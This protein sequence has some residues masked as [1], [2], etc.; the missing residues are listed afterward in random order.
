MV[1]LSWRKRWV[2]LLCAISA[3]IGWS[4]LGSKYA[5]EAANYVVT[6]PKLTESIRIVQL[7]DLHNSEF[8]K[9]NTRLIHIVKKQRP[10]IILLTGDMLN[11]IEPETEVLVRLIEKLAEIAPVY[12]SYGNHEIAHE[13]AYGTDMKDLY[14]QAG[15]HMLERTYID[16]QIKGQQVRIG[17]IYGYCFPGKYA[18]KYPA[19]KRE[20]DYLTEFQDTDRLS[21]LL[22]HLPTNWIRR[23]SLDAWAVDYVFSGHAHGGQMRLPIIGGVYV[24]GMGTFPGQMCGLYASQDGQCRMVLSRGLGSRGVVPRINNTPEIVIADILPQ[25][26]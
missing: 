5:L 20:A 12:A 16:A 23:N 3:L 10:D 21:I 4:I 8:G 24:P 17:G 15:A 6:S 11:D 13:K 18:E 1:S 7:S 19:L 2:A 14:A 25:M 26:K 9:N 22:C